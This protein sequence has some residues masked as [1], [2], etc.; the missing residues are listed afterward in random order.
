MVPDSLDPL[1]RLAIR[2]GSDKFGAH[3]YTPVYHRMFA[4]IR[5]KP[6][7]LLEI[8][9]GGYDKPKAGGAS[10]RMW[11][12]YFPSARVVGLDIAPKTLDLPPRI[13][14]VAG[15]QTDLDLLQRLF[16]EHGSFDIVI[17]DGSHI[18][19]HVLTTFQFLYPRLHN[20]AIYVVE[21]TQTAFL[22][23]A[24]GRPS[25]Q[26]TI[27]SLAHAIVLSMHKL[28]G[29][30]IAPDR[31]DLA[32]LGNLTETVSFHRN[33]IVFERGDNT[34]PSNFGLNLADN[35]VQRVL[36]LIEQEAAANPSSRAHLS[37]IDMAIWG[38]DGQKAADLAIQAAAANPG[39]AEVLTE[40]VRM[41]ETA[42]R[43]AEAQAINRL[44]PSGA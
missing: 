35:A 1:S 30:V 34:Y 16:D 44:L 18:V 43:P 7:R 14:T 25:G 37:R 19:E 12:E 13:T 21:D 36:R 28:E 8:G 11:A 41:M 22:P 32:M 6:L 15:S 4:P 39:D 5:D 9:I 31:P 40:L 20:G 29:H 42:G 10:L 38:R 26:D 17:D 3:L 27:F 23:G 2:F 33:L 24:G